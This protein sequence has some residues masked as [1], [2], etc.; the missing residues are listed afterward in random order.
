[1]SDLSMLG[2]LT[3]EEAKLLQREYGGK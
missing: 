3:D 2:E 1:L